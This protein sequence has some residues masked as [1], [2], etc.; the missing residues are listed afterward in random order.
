[1]K[2]SVFDIAVIGG[3]PAGIFSSI[4]ASENNA[5]VVLFDKNEEAGGKL[6][7]TGNFRCNITNERISEDDYVGSNH[8][9]VKNVFARFSNNDLI[10]FF[11]DLNVPFL[12]EGERYYPLTEKSKTILSALKK[13]M[14]ENNVEIICKATAEEVK[15]TDGLYEIKT[16][17]GIFQSSAVIICTG[18]K[19][20]SKRFGSGGGYKIAESLGHRPTFLRPGLTS[21]NETEGRF[22]SL[23]GVTLRSVISL[24][25]EGKRVFKESGSLLFTHH[26]FSGPAVMDASNRL[27]V[28]GK[29]SAVI[30]IDFFNGRFRD[31]DRFYDTLIEDREKKISKIFSGSIPSSLSEIIIREIKI[32]ADLK[33]G[34]TKKE[35][36]MQI[37]RAFNDCRVKVKLNGNFDEAQVTVGGI[38][39]DEINPKSMESKLVKNLFFAGEI[40]DIAGDCGG[41]NLQ[42]AFS[43]GYIAGTNAR[44]VGKTT[45]L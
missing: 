44:C 27:A 35:S 3:G 16:S 43:T 33:V 32:N 25:I 6:P 9:F 23:S 5:S 38:A 2:K 24:E 15:I 1:L 12:K 42:F 29:E 20:Y 30:S 28:S 10:E 26:G 19:S 14:I 22:A 11:S 18:G 17:S 34:E 37:F 8:L 4:F 39:T 41:Y 31:F 13:K 40:I 21:F 36:I 7:I 45:H